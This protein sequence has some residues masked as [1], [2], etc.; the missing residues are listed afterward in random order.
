MKTFII[1]TIPLI[2]I[3]VFPVIYGQQPSRPR[4]F[5][6]ENVRIITVSD[7]AIERGVI[8][9]ENGLIRS[10]GVSAEIPANAW[11]ID[12]QGL[13]VYPGF[14]NALSDLELS[15]P[16]S[17]ENNGNESGRAGEDEELSRGA[18]DRPASTPWAVAADS[19]S[20]TDENLRKWRNRGFTAVAVAP[21]DGIFPG[22][23]SLINLT[24]SPN[25]ERVIEPRAALAIQLPED[26]EGY[27]GYPRALLGRIAYIRQVF[28]DARHYA[29]SHQIYDAN[30]S[31]LER[32]RDDRVLEPIAESLQRGRTIL[33]P[34]NSA[35]EIRRA[36]DLA[37]EISPQLVIYGAQAGY[38]T[39]G[40]LR[41]TSSTA[42]VDVSWPEE[43][44]DADPEEYTPLRVLRFRDRA[45]SSPMELAS[46]N[47]AFAFFGSKAE[48]PEDF[49]KGVAKAIEKGLPVERAVQALTLDA[50]RVY[51]L[52]DRLGSLE[53]GKIANLVVFEGDPFGEKSRPKMVFIDGQ[54]YDV[55]LPIENEEEEESEGGGER[56]DSE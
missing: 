40:E 10:V 5:A 16:A 44:E 9:L 11:R 20:P 17:E 43:R 25:H 53:P 37:S 38:E 15:N 24:E 51:G 14:V 32:P 8:V 45:P 23:V 2:G 39:A 22:Q 18:D 56:G 55:P 42:L 13:T 36:L 6:L 50:A 1:R 3:L 31:G 7:S 47:V 54:K 33:Y 21:R 49:M 46:V 52:D 35:I 29:Q 28:L 19:F 34:A 12:G 41:A 27:R 48:S 4:S 30:P 26:Q